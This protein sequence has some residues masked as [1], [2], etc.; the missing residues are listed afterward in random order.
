MLFD[1]RPHGH[2]MLG[3]E[4]RDLSIGVR[5]GLQ[6]SACSSRGRRAEIDQH[7]FA[8]LFGLIEC[9]VHIGS[10]PRD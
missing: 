10:V 9:G 2:K 1:V 5:L 4:V 7:G 6:P 3:D 8:C